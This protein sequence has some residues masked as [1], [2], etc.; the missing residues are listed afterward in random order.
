MGVGVPSSL[1]GIA[2]RPHLN[3]CQV[4]KIPLHAS[5]LQSTTPNVDKLGNVLR[6]LQL[7]RMR[8]RT[9]HKSTQCVDDYELLWFWS[10]QLERD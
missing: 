4:G 9:H 1:F 5:D 8:G 10:V 2:N 3:S 7:I 6:G